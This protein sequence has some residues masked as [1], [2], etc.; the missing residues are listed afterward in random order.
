MNISWKTSRCELSSYSPLPSSL[1]SVQFC[2]ETL[3]SLLFQ[4]PNYICC[5]LNNYATKQQNAHEIR[6][7]FPINSVPNWVSFH[8]FK[9]F[10]IRLVC[11]KHI[12]CSLRPTCL[13]NNKCHFVPLKMASCLCIKRRPGNETPGSKN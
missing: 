6:V 3:N 7:F 4:K 13:Y 10:Y 9:G 2:Q 8:P 12:L 5:V 11:L 1:L